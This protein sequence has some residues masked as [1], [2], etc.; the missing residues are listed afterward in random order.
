MKTLEKMVEKEAS[1]AKKSKMDDFGINPKLKYDSKYFMEKA[2]NLFRLQQDYQSLVKNA[3]DLS[4]LKS[5]SAIILD[6]MPGDRN[7]KEQIIRDPMA[8]SEYAEVLLNIG[9]KKMIQY[10]ENNFKLMIAKLP[11]DKLSEMAWVL[12]GKA[13]KEAEY[14]AA[15]KEKDLD[16][17]RQDLVADVSNK[18]SDFKNKLEKCLNNDDVFTMYWAQ[19]TMK[20]MRSKFYN[21][22]EVKGGKDK[23]ITKIDENKAI[24]YLT[25]LPQTKKEKERPSWYLNAAQFMYAI[26]AQ[27]A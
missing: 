20:T 19:E 24:K 15:I 11:K 17:L 9:V 23:K 3:G 21:Q 25:D 5:L 1:G 22:F 18:Y 26:T 12:S 6:Y 27:A 4:A 16:H 13:K 8:V 7:Q 10:V 2:D 14:H